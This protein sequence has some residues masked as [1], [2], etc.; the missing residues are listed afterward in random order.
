MISEVDLRDWDTEVKETRL[1]L[2]RTK[3]LSGGE[4][5]ALA[6]FV[7]L[8]DKIVQGNKAQICALLKPKENSV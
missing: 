7:S 4:L 5:H 3:D 1:L 6:R 2:S 8:A